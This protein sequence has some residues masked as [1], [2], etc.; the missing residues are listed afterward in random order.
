MYSV[1]ML[2]LHGFSICFSEL[3][4]R[5]GLHLTERKSDFTTK[6]QEGCPCRDKEFLNKNPVDKSR[7]Q[8]ILSTKRELLSQKRERERKRKLVSA[9]VQVCKQ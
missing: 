7:I 9:L 3:A 8:T 5:L 6:L 1:S 2:G 4:H